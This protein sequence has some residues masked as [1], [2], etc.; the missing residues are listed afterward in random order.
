MYDV[1]RVLL[2]AIII[3]LVAE[4]AKINATLGGFI[5]SLPIISLMAIIWLYSQ[6][7][8]MEKIAVLSYSTFWFV[9]PTLPF[10]LILPYLL[11]H[12]LHFYTSLFISLVI[13]LACYMITILVLRELGL[14]L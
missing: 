13:M 1:I 11:R 14:K 5:K 12:G 7:H 2:S 9:L 3:V 6:T 4:L 8:D 10:F